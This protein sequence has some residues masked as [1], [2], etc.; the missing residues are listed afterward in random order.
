MTLA[1][2]P[3]P[4][5][6]FLLLGLFQPGRRRYRN[7]VAGPQRRGIGDRPPQFG[8]ERVVVIVVVV[9]VE[10]WRR[11]ARRPFLVVG[12][13]RRRGRPDTARI[14]VAAVASVCVVVGVVA[15]GFVVGV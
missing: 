13:C 15:L 7:V 5:G 14:V 8:D 11:H 10:R 9:I 3:P 4:P 1:P 12:R 2:E 6:N